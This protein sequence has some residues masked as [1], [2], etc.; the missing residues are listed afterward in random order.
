MHVG[1]TE[2]EHLTEGVEADVRSGGSSPDEND[3]GGEEEVQ[4]VGLELRS[5]ESLVR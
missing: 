5:L 3:G 4:D 2:S 1:I